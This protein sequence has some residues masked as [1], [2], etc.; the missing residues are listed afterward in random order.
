[1]GLSAPV[2]LAGTGKKWLPPTPPREEQV[3]HNGRKLDHRVVL[4]HRLMGLRHRIFPLL[5]CEL[6][7]HH[8]QGR[9]EKHRDATANDPTA[10][11]IESG[12]LM[13]M[14]WQKMSTK[15]SMVLPAR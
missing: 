10:I 4:R 9:Y 2:A 1:V 7:K 3:S 8:E 11:L 14:A 13:P 6:A 5:G 15:F 12:S